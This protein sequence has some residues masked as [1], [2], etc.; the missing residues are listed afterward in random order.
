[1]YFLHLH[2]PASDIYIFENNRKKKLERDR[3]SLGL[4]G[5]FFLRFF[6]KIHISFLT[7]NVRK[8]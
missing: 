2:I 8:T 4:F 1:M 3:V 7:E 5:L 6:Y